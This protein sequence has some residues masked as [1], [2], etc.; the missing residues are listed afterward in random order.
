[1]P[2]YAELADEDAEEEDE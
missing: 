1:M 2:N